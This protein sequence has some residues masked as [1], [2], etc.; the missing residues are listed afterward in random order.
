MIEVIETNLAVDNDNRIHDHQSRIIEVEDWDTYCNAF[1]KYDGR[2]IRFKSK[3]MPGNSI[4][5][6]R[7]IKELLYDDYH[8]SCAVF[9]YGEVYDD[10]IERHF[11]YKMR[12]YSQQIKD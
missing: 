4:Q 8:L 11:A 1:E 9:N 2:A 5:A 12:T 10:F 6:N 3:Q 7:K